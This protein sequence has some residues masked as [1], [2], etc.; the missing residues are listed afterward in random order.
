[1]LALPKR[2]VKHRILSSA[3]APGL[4]AGALDD[5]EADVHHS[6]GDRPAL[7]AVDDEPG[8]LPAD[9]SAVDAN[10]GE[11]GVRVGRETEVAETEHRH[12]PW[13]RDAARVRL[14]DHAGCEDIRAAEHGVDVGPAR[15]QVGEASAAVTEGAWRWDNAGRHLA[16]ADAG[17]DL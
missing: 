4:G 8:R 5:G 17:G 13:H 11:G 9:G 7:G 14:G 10:G 15:E 2:V 16:R 3:S 6:F 12:A 1:M